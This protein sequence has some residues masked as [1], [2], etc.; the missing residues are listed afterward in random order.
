MIDHA[1]LALPSKYFRMTFPKATITIGFSGEEETLLDSPSMQAASAELKRASRRNRFEPL[2]V[3]LEGI[4]D[5]AAMKRG[6]TYT[7]L[8]TNW[9]EI[10]GEAMAAISTPLSV[11]YGR[12]AVCGTLY[13]LAS[14]ARAQELAMSIPDVV[15]RINAFHGYRAI[16]DVRITQISRDSADEREPVDSLAIPIEPSPKIRKIV[17]EAIE[18]IDDD[19]LRNELSELGIGLLTRRYSN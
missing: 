10:V 19:E 18:G 12:N 17:A 8:L 3:A 15:E 4:V 1:K 7:R 6:F 16:S 5:K 11:R 9:S 2:S 14:G 13:V